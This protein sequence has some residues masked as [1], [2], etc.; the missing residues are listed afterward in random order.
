MHIFMHACAHQGSY[1]ASKFKNSETNFYKYF[2]KALNTVK[3]QQY[4]RRNLL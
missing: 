2:E 1:E 3:N 4:L